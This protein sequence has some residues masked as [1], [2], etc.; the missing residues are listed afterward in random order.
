[1]WVVKLGGSVCTD[2]LL[3]HWL[4][5]LADLGGGRVTVVPGGG[6][7]ANEVRHAQREWQFDDL[8]AHNMAV[9]AM[10]QTAYQLH[11]LNP[12]LRLAQRKTDIHRVL[13]TGRTALWLP[14]ELQREMVD[15]RTNWDASSDT[16]AFD[17]ARSLNAERLVLIKSCTIDHRMSLA[18]LSARGVIDGPLA[19]RAHGAPFPIELLH[20]A[21]LAEMRAMLLGDVRYLGV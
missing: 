10:A 20:K 18:D 12:A 8:A 4:D 3:P 19:T 5:L 14:L 1:M 11:A 6:R 7:F 9:L 21:E 2:P 17:L 15:D 16:I 13:H